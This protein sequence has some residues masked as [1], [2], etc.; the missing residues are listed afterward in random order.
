M[1]IKPTTLQSLYEI[2]GDSLLTP[3]EVADDAELIKEYKEVM[4]RFNALQCKLGN[5]FFN[6]LDN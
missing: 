2:N 1:I 3:V 6:Q 4:E 5:L